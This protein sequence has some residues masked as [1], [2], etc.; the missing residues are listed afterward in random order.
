[1]RIATTASLIS[2]E[3][4]IVVASVSAI[5]N[6]GDPKLFANLG[7]EISKGQYINRKIS[8]D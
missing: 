5:Y 3:D 4:T 6:V 2:R 1:M 8:K 7:F